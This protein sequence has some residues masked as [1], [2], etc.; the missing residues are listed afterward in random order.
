MWQ[1]IIVFFIVVLAG[2][3]TLWRFSQ[4]FTGKSSCCGGG[5]TCQGSCGS[6]TDGC[7]GGLGAGGK[8]I[9]PGSAHKG[10]SSCC[11]SS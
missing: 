8:P 9:Q 5:C 1:N 10:G 6:N 2:G 3:L 4:K 11:H 7:S